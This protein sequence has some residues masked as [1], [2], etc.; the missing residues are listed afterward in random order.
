MPSEEWFRNEAK[1]RIVEGDVFDF[2]NPVIPCMTRSRAY[3][4][5]SKSAV[6]R[7]ITIPE[8]DHGKVLFADPYIF[9]ALWE[10]EGYNSD[11]FLS[12]CGASILSIASGE[13]VKKIAMPVMGGRKNPLKKMAAF[14]LGMFQMADHLDSAGL[15]IP[16]HVYVTNREIT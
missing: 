13:L 11:R 2:D 3:G 15:H 7:G 10:E 12:D 14:E 4:S 1:S 16:E 6:T 8:L 5:I 9:I